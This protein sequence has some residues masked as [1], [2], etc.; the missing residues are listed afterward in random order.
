MGLWGVESTLAAI[1]IG[2]PG[3]SVDVKGNIVDVKDNNVDVK[4][5]SVDVSVEY[6]FIWARTSYTSSWRKSAATLYIFA[7]KSLSEQRRDM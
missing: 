1:G 7:S 3:N 6:G 4:G 2:G 5:N